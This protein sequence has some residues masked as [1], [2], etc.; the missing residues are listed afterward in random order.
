MPKT[1]YNPF[2]KEL[3]ALAQADLEKLIENKIA[4]G[5]YIEYK[6]RVPLDKSDFDR[7]KIAKSIA[8]FAN[9]KGGW[10]FWGIDCTDNFPTQLTGIDTSTHTNFQDSLSQVIASNINPK[11][12]Y[13]FKEV[14]LGNGAAIFVI[15]VE[16][17]PLPPYITSQGIIYQREN[18]ESKPIKDRYIIEKLNERARDYVNSIENFSQFDL[19]QTRGQTD[20]KQS[21]LELY[22]FPKPFNSFDFKKFH[23]SDFFKNVAFR[24]YQSVDF[25]FSTA[26][27]VVPMTLSFNSIYSTGHS[28]IIRALKEDNLI[29]KSI[30]AELFYNGNLKFTVP[31]PSFHADSIPKHY[32]DSTVAKYLLDTYSPYETIKEYGALPHIRHSEPTEVTRRKQTDF[33]SHVDFIDGFDLIMIITILIEKYKSVLQDNDFEMSSD[34]GLR[35]RVTNTWRKFLFFDND[36]YLEKIKLFN[37]PITP[38]NDIEMPEFGNGNS[39]TVQLDDASM[40]VT[41]AHIIL[42]RIGLPDSSTIKLGEILEKGIKRFAKK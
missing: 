25:Q 31:V 7:V 6:S 14:P 4:E 30:T 8:S 40:T 29:Y 28:L 13:H 10:I 36:D 12:I 41:I 39:F 17:S 3:D 1:N 5:W 2:E 34:V 24:F 38:K 15:L 9:T 42:E 27:D 18:N 22:L 20:S 21:F 37:I 32:Q 23:E 33:V 11:P 19:G 35:A 16:E 26:E